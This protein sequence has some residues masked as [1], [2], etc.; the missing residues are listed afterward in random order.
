MGPALPGAGVWPAVSSRA[1]RLP[2][3]SSP[4]LS[5]PPT[6]QRLK[7]LLQKGM[8]PLWERRGRWR[9]NFLRPPCQGPGPLLGPLGCTRWRMVPSSIPFP[10]EVCSR[11]PAGRRKPVIPKADAD[12]PGPQRRGSLSMRWRSQSFCFSSSNQ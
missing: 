10:S 3:C 4:A 9:R 8:G 7:Y 6:D 5:V 11:G 1:T 12:G 2:G